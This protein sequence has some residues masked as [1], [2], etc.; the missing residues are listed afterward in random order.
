MSAPARSASV[1][2]SCWT[3]W[4]EDD[5]ETAFGEEVDTEESTRGALVWIHGHGAAGRAGQMERTTVKTM[6]GRISH[7]IWGM[8]EAP[9]QDCVEETPEPNKFNRRGIRIHYN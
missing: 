2:S 3:V 4:R 1:S 7:M 6:Y 8:H 5:W 9:R